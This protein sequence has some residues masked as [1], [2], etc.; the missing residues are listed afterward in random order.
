MGWKKG[1]K[2]ILGSCTIYCENG[3]SLLRKN[4]V[5]AAK[6]I[7]ADI[8]EFAAPEIGE[9]NSG[10]KSFKTAVESVG[11]Q[12]LR[13]HL[14]SGSK[15]KRIIPTKSTK[16][17]SCS[18]RDIFTN[19]SHWSCQLIFGT[20]LLWQC[21]EMLKGKSQLLTMSRLRMNKKFIQ[22]PYLMKA[23]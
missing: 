5:S 22:L 9:V 1:G 18:R 21:L 2:E 10:R 20:N 3:N 16:Q 17:T 11:K 15:E 23:A 7:G 19:I 12:T 4:V 8:L 14:G 6:S 13:K